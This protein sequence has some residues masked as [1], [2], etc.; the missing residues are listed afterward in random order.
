MRVHFVYNPAAGQ[1]NIERELTKCL[2]HLTERGWDVRLAVTDRPMQ[3]ADLARDA[4][5]AGL[6][7]V[8]AVGGDG[9][10]S[11]VA[12]GLVGSDTLL[13]VIPAGTTNVW[14]LQMHIPSLPPWHPRKVVDRVLSDLE[15]LGWHRPLGIPSWLSD[16]FRVMLNSEVRA[17]DTG[18]VNVRSFLLWAGVGFDA[19]V[20]E[21]VIPEDKRRYGALAYIAS[22]VA[23][24]VEYA[25]ARMHLSV[26]DR[27]LDDDVLMLVASN[28]RLYAG[29]VQM[30]PTAYLD[31]GLLDVC[32]FKGEGIAE[33]VRHATALLAG[34][35]FDESN[36]SYF[37]ADHL[38]VSSSPSQPVHADA[39]PCGVT[40]VDITVRPRSLRVLAPPIRD[41]RLF[42]RPKIGYLRDFE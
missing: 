22:G 38:A 40:P 7:M 34:R 10:V 8:V 27:E 18:L 37:Q 9:T 15:D 3:A 39:E 11:E 12:N 4:A 32:V 14:A 42:S 33:G 2:D 28:A 30:A 41:R 17:V 26:G 5:A 24:A 19:T 31:D 23:T 21:A 36:V 6:D 13:G 29:I 35:H 20:A 25:G 1:T 16:A